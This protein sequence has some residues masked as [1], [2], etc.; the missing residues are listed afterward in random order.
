MANP[1]DWSMDLQ[2]QIDEANDLSHKLNYE[3]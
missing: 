3:H 2:L 1:I